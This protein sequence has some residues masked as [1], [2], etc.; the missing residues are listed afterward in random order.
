M[1][2]HIVLLLFFVFI[3]Q[4]VEE[5]CY[6]VTS[7][8]SVI[9]TKWTCKELWGSIKINWWWIV[10]LVQFVL[11]ILIKVFII[12]KIK[13]VN[14]SFM[15]KSYGFIAKKLQNFLLEKYVKK[16]VLF[17]SVLVEFLRKLRVYFN[18]NHKWILNKKK[19]FKA[20]IFQN[21]W[22]LCKWKCK[23]RIGDNS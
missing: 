2:D 22:N 7:E 17:N 16:H 8:S 6:N 12:M 3:T 15:L 5:T 20:I 13:N 23:W 11:L 21:I 19:D 14:N 1:L 9:K 10:Q 4:L 18:A